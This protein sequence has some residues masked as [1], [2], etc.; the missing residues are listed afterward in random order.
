[1]KFKQRA[2]AMRLINQECLDKMSK[3]YL[4]ENIEDEHI[5]L[6]DILSLLNEWIDVRLELCQ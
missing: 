1:M 2:F 3:I 4:D 5:R 6:S